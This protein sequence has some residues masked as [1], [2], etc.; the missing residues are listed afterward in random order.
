MRI[1]SQLWRSLKSAAK[2]F[3][4]RRTP[5]PPG[6]ER[7][8][9]WEQS[10]P[11]GV[12]WGAEIKTQPLANLLDQAAE[13]YGEQPCISFR[14]RRFLYREIA[15]QVRRAAKGFQT[16]GVQK[17]IKVGLMLPNCPYAVICFYAVLKAGGTVVNINPLYTR[18][19]I[20]KQIEDSGICILVTLNMKALYPKIAP[21]LN[22]GGRLET[23]I[24]CSMSGVLKFHE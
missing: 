20:E 11:P 14:R 13:A 19:E 2:P 23:I 18:N 6:T 24:V 5:T 10:Y 17:G 16:L 3:W 8:Y 21:L 12:D 15:D 9:I 7:P 1:N 22:S 4:W